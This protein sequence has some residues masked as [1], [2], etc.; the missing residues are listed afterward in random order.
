M[1]LRAKYHTDSKLRNDGVWFD[2]AENS[3]GTKARV[4]L[5]RNGRG[6]HRWMKEFRRISKDKDIDSLSPEEDAELTAEVFARA[7]VVTWENLQLDDD[8][9]EL[10]HSEEAAIE[11]LKNPDWLDLLQDWQAKAS[12]VSNFQKRKREKELKN[13]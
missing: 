10:K 13:S 9:K 7:T 1:S 2:V 8:G 11:L 12:D 4:K 6:S 5:R 3:D